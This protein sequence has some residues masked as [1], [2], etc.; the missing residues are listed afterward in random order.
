MTIVDVHHDEE[1]FPDS[2]SFIPERW[3]DDPHTSDGTPLEHYMVAFGRG[4]RACL[5]I[6]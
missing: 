2:D 5:G 4:P 1:I 3:F 6:K